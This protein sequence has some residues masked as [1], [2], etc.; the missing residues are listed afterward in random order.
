MLE[1]LR[2]F[3]L[4]AFYPTYFILTGF[5]LKEAI[6]K[7]EAV[8]LFL[9]ISQV[10]FAL[11]LYLSTRQ[12]KWLNIWF[13]YKL[14]FPIVLLHLH[15]GL[16]LC[17]VSRMVRAGFMIFIGLIA[18]FHYLPTFNSD[19][20]N[21][22][23]RAKGQYTVPNKNIA[24]IMIVPQH[25]FSYAVGNYYG[26]YTLD[27]RIIT[28]DNP[29]HSQEYSKLIGLEKEVNGINLI[30][31]D[32]DIDEERIAKNLEGLFEVHFRKKDTQFFHE[33]VYTHP[34]NERKPIRINS[35]FF[36]KK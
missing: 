28:V 35:Y 22:T 29:F 15:H 4:F 11:S 5:I 3:S 34:F 32:N 7:K 19:L 12:V 9:I 1:L 20:T 21:R 6:Q 24:D 16:Y 33:E 14:F 31:I 30:F 8:S 26:G 18:F 25:P 2:D 27:N 10:L 17:K 23:L 36:I 13:D